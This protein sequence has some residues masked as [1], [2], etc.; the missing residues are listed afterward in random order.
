MLSSYAESE[1][2]RKRSPASAGDDAE[3]GDQ[4]AGE[5]IVAPPTKKSK[6]S[7]MCGIIYMYY[8]LCVI[9]IIHPNAVFVI[10]RRS[11]DIR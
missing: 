5:K 3:E 9:I 6:E 8:A 11:C 4:G 1:T 7:G 2:D 10:S